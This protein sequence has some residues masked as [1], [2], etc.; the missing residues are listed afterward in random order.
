M[1]VGRSLEIWFTEMDLA[2]SEVSLGSSGMAM[3]VVQ[4]QPEQ[5]SF[6][7]VDCKFIRRADNSVP[8]QTERCVEHSILVL[9]SEDMN[10]I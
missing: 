7:K 6:E 8:Q 9:Y 1:V 2:W 10:N 4:Y 5:K 3:V